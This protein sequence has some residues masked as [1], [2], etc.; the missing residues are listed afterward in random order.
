[1]FQALT[2]YA[3]L[4]RYKRLIVCDRLRVNT[5]YNVFYDGLEEGNL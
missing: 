4:L 3:N 5:L 2:I 1:M